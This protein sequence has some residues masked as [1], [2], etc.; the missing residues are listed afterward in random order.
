M[1]PAKTR[2][3]NRIFAWAAIATSF[4]ILLSVGTT[5]GRMIDWAS[6]EM[7]YTPPTLAGYSSDCL[8]QDGQNIILADWT[9]DET[10]R[11]LE[12]LVERPEPTQPETEPVETDPQEPT[13]ITSEP[14][15]ETTEPT[16]AATEPTDPTETTADAPAEAAE[17]PAVQ[18]PTE[19]SEA[20]EPTWSQ[21]EMTVT[22][23]ETAQLHLSSAIVV[24]EHRIVLTLQRLPDA[25]GLAQA[26]Q[27]TIVL[28]WQGLT[29]TVHINMLPYGDLESLTEEE[30]ETLPEYEV[31][32]TLDPVKVRDTIAPEN[33]VV[34][35]KL[36]LET[37]SDFQILMSLGV[38]PLHKVRWSMDGVSYSLLYD[39][40]E[41]SIPYPYADGWDGTVF[42]DFGLALKPEERPT[43]AVE[44]TGYNRE[45]FTPVIQAIPQPAQLVLKAANMPYIIEMNT[46]WGAAV[47]QI[48][49][50][51]RLTAD[52][53]GNLSYTEDLSIK[54]TVTP[55]GIQMESA[56]ENLLPASG[57][58]R[59]TIQWIWN[60]ICIEEQIIYFFINTN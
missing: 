3:Y 25:P 14:T 55:T 10:Q 56:Q 49:I 39:S 47:P 54:T 17:E 7:I 44:A 50:I 35:V 19:E 36:N 13:E 6:A 16:E 57:S 5:Q 24:E 20:T 15:E 29:G 33:P 23:D 31:D 48:P 52:E 40:A 30:E 12:I 43:I 26:T 21:D 32:T 4:A 53:V 1:R 59:M 9:A 37:G 34:C 22:M 27:M 11:V 8:T 45:E 51:E 42:L 58:Y 38:R 60:D 2:R 18:E 28:Q 46:R 41:I